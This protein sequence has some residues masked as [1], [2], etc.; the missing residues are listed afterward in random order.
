MGDAIYDITNDP[1]VGE[2]GANEQGES[3]VA[4]NN[5]GDILVVKQDSEV[6]IAEAA[7]A[8]YILY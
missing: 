4:D 6:T 7:G 1:A 3:G 5:G 2:G 8:K